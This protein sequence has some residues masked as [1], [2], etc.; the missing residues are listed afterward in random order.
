MDDLM[1]M[2]ID[3]ESPSNI[4]NRIKDV[5][6]TKTAEKVEGLRPEVANAL[7]SELESSEDS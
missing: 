6:Y 3:D 2:I 4:S 5:L 1:D 7:F